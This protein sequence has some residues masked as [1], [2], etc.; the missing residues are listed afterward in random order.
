MNKPK[1]ID[2]S[3]RKLPNC[4]GCGKKEAGEFD[5]PTNFGPWGDFCGDCVD[6]VSDYARQAIG[7]RRVNSEG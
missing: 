7:F 1:D 2:W 5:V 6:K 3:G 4:Q